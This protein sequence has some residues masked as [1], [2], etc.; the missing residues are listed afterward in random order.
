MGGILP[1]MVVD[2]CWLTR[3]IR[4]VPDYPQPGRHLPRH[5]AAARLIRTRSASRSTPSPTTSPVSTSTAWSGIEARGF[6]LAAPVAYRAGRVFVPV[7]KAGKLPWA[8]AREE[9]VLEYGTDKLE[10]HRDAMLPGE[11]VLVVDDV[12]ATGGTAAAAVRLVEGLGGEV[13][14]LGF[15]IEL[16]FLAGRAAEGLESTSRHHP[17]AEHARRRSRPAAPWPPSTGSCRGGGTRRRRR[18]GRARSSTPTAPRTQ[19]VRRHGSSGPTRSPPSA[20]ERPVPQV[21]ASGTSTTRCRWPGSWP[22]S[23]STTPRS[24]PPSSTTRSRT[25]RSP[26]ADLERQF[27]ADVAPIVDGVTKLDRIRFDS[28]EEQQAAT[29]RKMLVAMAKDLRVL[30][31]KLADRL[32][33][34]R[35]LAALSPEQAGAH[36]AGDARHLRAAGPPPRHAGAEAAARGPVLRRPP[37]EALRR[38]RPPRRH[39][40]RPSA[41]IYLAEVVDEVQGRL[42]ELKIEA[43]VTGRGKHLWSIY[44]KMVLRGRSS[45]TSSTWSASASSSTR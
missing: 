45:T 36:R 18:R 2:A 5:H 22:T 42:A 3:H 43:E 44:E 28:R 26:S 17:T 29:M 6:I 39:C 15:L 12:L 34:M 37:P 16:A 11:R 4:D 13:V 27:G 21:A 1:V 31:I 10:I 33:N 25:P 23:A 40:A 14:G 24:P 7:R 32:H 8:V 41:T 38:D 30:I 9:Y 20:H 19:G 35:T